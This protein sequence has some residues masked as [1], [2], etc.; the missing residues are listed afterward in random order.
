MS[1]RFDTLHSAPTSAPV[2]V[3][4]FAPVGVGLLLRTK[5]RAL[6]N[7]IVQGASTSPIKVS[8]TIVFLA[9]IWLGLYALFVN[10]FRYVGQT[11][12]EAAVAIP[13][14]FNVFFVAMLVML[15]ISNAIIAYMS[16]FSASEAAYLLTAPVAPSAYVT[17]KYLETLLFSS[18]SLVLLG[19]PLMLAMAEVTREPWYFYPLFLAFFLCFVPIPGALGLMLAYLTAR[20]LTRRLR[21]RLISIAALTGAFVAVWTLATLKVDDDAANTWLRD[22]LSRVSFVQSAFLPSAWVAGGV[23]DA[24]HYHTTEALLYLCVTLANGLFGAMVAIRL[25]SRGMFT[26]LDRALSNRGSDR[27]AAV[28]PA[29]GVAG[30]VF[31]YLP[32]RM[33]LIAAKDLRT[34]FRDP[35]QWTQLVILFGLMAL[36]L[37]NLPRFTLQRPLQGWGMIIPFLNFGAISFILA[38]FTSRFVFPLVSLEGRQL[39]LIGLLPVTAWQILWAKFA[40]AM[41]VAVGVALTVTVLA[42]IMLQM[43]VQWAL[44]QCA[45]TFAVCVGLCGFAVGFGARLP[46]FAERNAA[47]IANGLGGTINLIAS[48]ALVLLMLVGMAYVGVHN[49]YFGFTGPVDGV[50]LL[51]AGAIAGAGLAGGLAVM[52]VGARHLART[53]V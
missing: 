13:L 39:W 30:Y 14:V 12:L 40:F 21:R 20:W 46:M 32:D 33:R 25:T 27:R 49:R 19:L 18:W 38:T 28:S 37:V 36:Y 1:S 6:W 53:E 24:L 9:A 23:D 2:G 10:I 29:A 17:L 7:R 8:T 52:A 34:F 31:F 44:L 16:L 5:L 48:V 42:A 51:T 41:T 3:P 35:M 45:V 4:T 47:R 15:T 50:T 11:P 43:P 22:F 26:A